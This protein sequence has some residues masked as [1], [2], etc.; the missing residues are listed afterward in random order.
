MDSDSHKRLEWPTVLCVTIGAALLALVIFVLSWLDRKQYS[1]MSLGAKGKK[2]DSSSPRRRTLE[3]P[4]S[5]LPILKN[6]LDFLRH[7]DHLHDWIFEQCERFEGRPW[8]FKVLGRPPAIVF[9]DPQAFEDILKTHFWSF[10]KGEDLHETFFELVGDGIFAVDGESWSMQRKTASHLF[11]LRELR[12]TMAA[13]IERHTA[14][15]SGVLDR[16]AADKKQFDLFALLNKFTMGAFCDL[17]FGVDITCLEHEQEEDS[18]HPFQGAFDRV[19]QVIRLRM[20]RPRW[21][22]KLQRSLNL[23]AERTL[24]ADM[25]VI[26]DTVYQIIRES[27]HT[28][29]SVSFPTA[30]PAQTTIVS[31]S[32]DNP[33]KLQGQTEARTVDPKYLRDIVVGFL[34]AGRDTTVQT[35]SW[36]FLCLSENPEVEAKLYQELTQQLPECL[37]A[38]TK[39]A[40][41]DQVQCLVYLDAVLHETLRLYP[42]VAFNWK[43]A[44]RDCVLSD[45]T[46]VPKDT[47]AAFPSHALGRM[48]HVWGEDAKHF[49]P[50][51]WIDP[52]TGRVRSESS[53]KL[54]AFHAGPR[55]CL[56]KNLA[57][58][59][60]K[61]V[62]ATLLSRFQIETARRSEGEVKYGMS[63]TLPMKTPLPTRVAR[64]QASQLATQ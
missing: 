1:S 57:M 23:G 46:L 39:I 14:M 15:L 30:G 34:L 37:G 38:G 16:F 28:Q 45:R 4:I 27:L 54:I 17:G 43:I 12:D 58:M 36:L 33:A 21:L 31:L 41:L 56:G 60:M 51:R 25:P 6:T 26:D 64:R 7:E 22:W 53:F 63:L 9:S 44:V 8:K 20:N 61:I 24:R 2:Q 13:V 29:K 32:L 3:E 52:E 59:E 35:M 18:V 49:R 50:E 55:R 48:T 47:Y 40:T 11:T 19:Q 5:T 42:P 10:E 62:V